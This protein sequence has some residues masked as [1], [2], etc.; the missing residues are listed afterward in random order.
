VILRGDA[1][2]IPLADESVQCVVTSPPYWLLRD[3]KVPGQTG[4]EPTP[5]EFVAELVTVFREV[6]RVLRDDGTLWL[7]IG[8]SYSGAAKYRTV[9]NSFAKSTLANRPTGQIDNLTQPSKRGSGLAD[10]QLV[11]IPWRVAFALQ[12]D[13]WFLRSDVIWN[14][15]NA[16][17]SSCSDRPACAHEYIFL[18]TK[19][20]TY[21][22]D[23]EAV[24]EPAVST[25]PH[26]F[27]DG[28]KSKQRGHSRQHAGFNGRYAEKIAKEGVPTTRNLRDVW[29]MAT[30]NCAEEHYAAFPEELPRKCILAGC[31]EGGIVLDPF[32]GSGTTVKVA[33]DL[34]RR[35]IGLELGKQYIPMARRR[36]SQLVLC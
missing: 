9:A 1:R 25:S 32:V 21:Y 26:H 14:K 35:G 23:H 2:H 28:A 27:V 18:F 4:Q 30:G 10:K 20:S 34:G 5:A 36:T 24:K 29:T 22:Y 19:R 17:P 13:G 15:S 3:Y 7:N 6:W 8:D 16:M 33:Q 12:E 11:G 31:P